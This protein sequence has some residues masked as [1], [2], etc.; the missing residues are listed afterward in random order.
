MALHVETIEPV[1]EPRG[2]TTVALAHGFTQNARCWG[3]F[4]MALANET[5][6]VLAVDLPGHGRSAHDDA[7]L[8]T[9]AKLTVEAID[10]AGGAATWIGYSMGGRVLLHAALKASATIERLVLIGA[11]PGLRDPADR[12]DRRAAD[13]RLA[14]RLMAD[15]LESFLDFWLD[16]P[17]FAAL[18]D[19]ASGRSHR[20]MNRPAGL[21]ASLRNCGTGT[22][23]PLWDRLGELSM[24]VLIIAGERDDKFRAIGEA[25][26][27]AI[28]ANARFAVIEGA[29][30]ACHL[31]N[32]A[33]TVAAILNR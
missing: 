6:P 26:A 29:G 3:D 30:H 27:A 11:T 18:D 25:M 19:D 21:A 15:G 1:A 12:A 14:D 2:T 23:E 4:G 20:L 33:A 13:A 8:P 5:G 9:A 28:G 17:L 31:E 16:L 7:D 10:S 24:P 22:Q 32:P